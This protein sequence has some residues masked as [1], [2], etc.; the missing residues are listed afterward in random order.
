MIIVQ[1]SKPICPSRRD[2]TYDKE[3]ERDNLRQ[4]LNLTNQNFTDK[5]IKHYPY[6][7]NQISLW[8]Y[9]V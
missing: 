5:L 9:V 8:T 4:W 7:P 3:R 6:Y 2:K 1:S